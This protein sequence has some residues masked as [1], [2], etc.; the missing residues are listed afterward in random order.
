MA[1]RIGS[2]CTAILLSIQC[3]GQELVYNTFLQDSVGVGE[4]ADFYI[5]IEESALGSIESIDLSALEEM[6]FFS[7]SPAQ[8][9]SIIAKKADI[10]INNL[11][12]WSDDNDDGLVSGEELKWEKLENNGE[13][14]YRNKINI[15][16][17]DVG[18]YVIEGLDYKIAAS[19]SK[20]NSASIKATF[21]DY[22][23]EVVDSTGLAPIKDIEKTGLSAVDLIP[24]LLYILLPALLIFLFYRYWQKKK[25]AEL[26]EVTKEEVV[27]PPDV[28]ALSELK[29]LRRKELWQKG[30]IKQY[31][32]EL[33]H[34]VREY[35]EGRYSIKALENTTS[36]IIR[37]IKDKSFTTDD[38]QKLSR[39]LQISDLV[40]FAK[41]KPEVSIHETF[42]N[43]AITFVQSTRILV[44]LNREEE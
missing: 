15:T 16:F 5:T 19:S 14:I 6:K 22:Q 7:A 9:D 34:I 42:M 36:E 39:I 11:G 44:E 40:K 30:E 8:S 3:Y 20:T 33:S 24:I 4:N 37:S 12:V 29:D 31:Q 43:D 32:S 10:S 13:V 1:L 18:I 38:Q 41:A 2:I 25:V 23:L 21:V 35:L 28:K 26:G 27:I 17:F